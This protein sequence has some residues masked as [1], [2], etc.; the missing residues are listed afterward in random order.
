MAFDA[1]ILLRN[2]N[3]Q[4]SLQQAV[5]ENNIRFCSLASVRLR[6]RGG[7][8]KKKSRARRGFEV[9]RCI[10]LVHQV[11]AVPQQRR[12]C[13][14]LE[15]RGL[16]SFRTPQDPNTMHYR[17]RRGVVGKGLLGGV[18]VIVFSPA[19][20]CAASNADPWGGSVALTTDYLVRG[21][22]RSDNDPALQ[23]DLHYVADSGF[24]A[25]G[26]ASSA[27]VD[28]QQSWTAELNAYL[29]LAWSGGTDWRGKLLATYYAYPRTSAAGRS[30]D[31]GELDVDLYFRQWLGVSLSYSPDMPLPGPYAA[32][33]RVASN[34]VEINLQQ[35]LLERLAGTAGIGYEHVAGGG[36][37]GFVYWSLGLAYDLSPVSLSLSYADTDVA[38]RSLFYDGASR[39]RWI[40]TVI[41]RF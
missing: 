4:H 3:A 25:G 33:Q 6:T 13:R 17:S 19:V 31:Y 8:H 1:E 2:F 27:R 34:S 18:L 23:L 40:A 14:A 26:F 24:V 29:G 30:Y 41:R 37:S 21:I 36:A 22:S 35:P 15:S 39:G 7:S 38:A 5:Y 11:V 9:V 32:V 10:G 20:A 16:S 28:P 12:L